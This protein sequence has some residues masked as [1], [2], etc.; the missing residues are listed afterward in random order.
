MLPSAAI[1][2]RVMA[3]LRISSILRLSN[4]T[5]TFH[6]QHLEQIGAITFLYDPRERLVRAPRV[7]PTCEITPLAEQIMEEGE[8]QR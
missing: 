1:T 5:V 4:A 8:R 2:S 7:T 6:V 3:A